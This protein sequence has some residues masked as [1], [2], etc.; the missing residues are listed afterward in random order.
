MNIA[1]LEEYVHSMNDVNDILGLPQLSLMRAADRRRIADRLESD[2]SP[3]SLT[4]DGELSPAEVRLRHRYLVR[5][6]Q[7]LQS[8]D[9]LIQ[10]EA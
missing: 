7:E 4:C 8:V 9:P 3:E 1:A 2:L 10:L 5:I 6:A